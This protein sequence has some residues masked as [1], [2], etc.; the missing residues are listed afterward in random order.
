MNEGDAGRLFL[1][2]LMFFIQL[3]S[4]LAMEFS[5]TSDLYR[6]GI[7]RAK[8]FLTPVGH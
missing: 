4:P 3:L 2:P 5:S 1:C 7:V 6:T 8:F